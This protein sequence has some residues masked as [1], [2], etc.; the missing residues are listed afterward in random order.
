M[1]EINRIMVL[2][3][4]RITHPARRQNRV[5]KERQDELNEDHYRKWLHPSRLMTHKRPFQR[6]TSRTKNTEKTCTNKQK[7]H[8]FN[9]NRQQVAPEPYDDIREQKRTKSFT[10][11]DC[12]EYALLPPLHETH[13]RRRSDHDPSRTISMLKRERAK[14]KKVSSIIFPEDDQE[15]NEKQSN[16]EW[17][18]SSSS[19]KTDTKKKRIQIIFQLFDS[20]DDGYLDKKDLLDLLSMVCPKSCP[21]FSVIQ[22]KMRRGVI[23]TPLSLEQFTEICENE[24]IHPSQPSVDSARKQF[25]WSKESQGANMCYNETTDES[26]KNSQFD[27]EKYNPEEVLALW[28]LFDVNSDGVVSKS[29]IRH[30]LDDLGFSSV[31]SDKEIDSLF[32]SPDVKHL[33]FTQFKNL[34][35]SL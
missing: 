29:E 33:Q 14:K 20:N 8:F 25:L 4:F 3:L 11:D 21:E 10:R 16:T 19:S 9:K 22:S 13:T 5:Q 7:H 17:L 6:D 18:F 24:N 34:I 31:F 2:S 28:N 35:N 1:S 15:T 32:P 12:D 26:C 23:T 30:V 27:Q